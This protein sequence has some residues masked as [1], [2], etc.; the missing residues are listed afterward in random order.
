[1][2]YY[3]EARAHVKALKQMS[4]DNRRRQERRAELYEA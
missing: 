4:E 2:S 3:Q 1:M